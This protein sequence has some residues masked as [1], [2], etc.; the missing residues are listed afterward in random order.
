MRL[1]FAIAALPVLLSLTGCKT[2]GGPPLTDI[3]PEI[4]ATLRAREVVLS[5]GD[6]IAVH[7]PNSPTWNQELE[8]ASDGSASFMGIGSLQVAGMSINT[9]RASLIEA[10]SYILD[11]PDLSVDVTEVAARTVY[12]M[13]EVGSP[14]EIVLGADS[15]LTF[16][17]ALARA[18]GPLKASAYLEHTML[19]RW[20]PA[21]G[22]QQAWKIDATEEYWT[23]PVP[24]YLQPYDV[25]FV[26]NTPIDEVGIW[27]DN[28][29][30][31]M[32]PFPYVVSSSP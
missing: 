27:V 1:L 31:R 24:V 8:I 14:G 25:L 15:N 21:T 4:N 7:F 11:N 16:V 22:K 23:G 30:R 17:Q 29:I 19:V 5:P 6:Q 18:G 2:S 32:I 13:G 28:Y 12:V 9:L 26:P 3:A 10:Y 20:N